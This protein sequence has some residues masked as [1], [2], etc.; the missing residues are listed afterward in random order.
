MSVTV[1]RTFGKK[2]AL[3]TIAE[4]NH[5]STCFAK[6]H[7][8]T[9]GNSDQRSVPI[10]PERVDKVKNLAL[11]FY[12]FARSLSSFIMPYIELGA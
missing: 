8:V 5:A 10:Y 6:Q 4:R 12:T 2:S 1:I 3:K 9:R 11:V 7:I